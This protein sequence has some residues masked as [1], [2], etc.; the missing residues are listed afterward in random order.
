LLLFQKISYVNLTWSILTYLEGK[1][2]KLLTAALLMTLALATGCSCEKNAAPPEP[3][4]EMAPPAQDQM[5][6][7]ADGSE[8][9]MEEPEATE[10]SSGKDM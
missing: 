6:A 4:T 5:G 3:M 1:N 7:P 10:E 2:M 8:D 9:S